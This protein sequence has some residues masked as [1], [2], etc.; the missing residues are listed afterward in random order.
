MMKFSLRHTAGLT[1][2][3]VP[4]LAVAAGSSLTHAQCTGYSITSST[5]AVIEPGTADTGN[6]A[7]NAVTPL[8]LPFPVSLYGV[9]YTAATVST[10]GTL[11]FTT[12]S[13]TAS[14]GC[15]RSAALGVALLPHW[16]DLRTDGAAPGIFTSVTG[17]APNR[18]FN[19]E[20][21]AVYRT[22]STTQLNFQVRLF[23]DNS[24]FEYVYGAIPQ[25][26]S[27]ATVGL[28]NGTAAGNQF[29]CNTSTLANGLKLSFAPINPATVLC[30]TG[31]ALPATVNNC[32]GA[33]SLLTV[34]V[35]PG[36][37]PDST[38]LAVTGNLA[39]IGGSATQQFYNDGTN[40]DAV[41]GDGT[42]SYLAT[43]PSTVTPGAK[44]VGF[45]ASDEQGRSG[46][47]NLTV[48]VNCIAPPSPVL[49]PDVYTFNITDVPRWGTSTNGAIT[50]YSVGTTSSNNG[51]YPVM[52]VDSSSYLPDYD[53][54]QHPVIS[55]NMYRLKKYGTAPND[56]WRFEA[57][58][59]S[60]LKHGFVSTNS[61][62]GSPAPTATWRPSIQ[63]YQNFGGDV[64]GVNCTDTYGGSLNG[65]QGSL[66]PK[67]V[68]NATLGTSLFIRN[69]G[70]GDA[71]T[72]ERL[73][74]PTADVTA[75]PAGT[76][77]FVDA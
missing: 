40:G 60:W 50:A 61:N 69:T 29:S 11:Q 66:G 65:S 57:I 58:G 1:R 27:S 67:N 28:Q 59:Q 38:G 62:C 70:T 44:T 17:T 25:S 39:A 34:Q 7:D 5:G 36:T 31:A 15:P 72:R 8:T 12:S 37:S 63:N 77:F 6:H 35:T 24:H 47:G 75:Q 55:Q 71:T 21:R 73:Q 33:T 16:D 43:V 20:W 76:R 49:G 23:E 14:N 18:V 13:T 42:F 19:I 46:T 10:N 3:M 52:W 2:F 51:D 4:A 64:L 48:T 68:V 54:T 53:N 9:S 32:S 26:G 56:Y 22:A 41:A 74:V 45:L 30:S